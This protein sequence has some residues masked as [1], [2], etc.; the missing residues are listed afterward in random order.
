MTHADRA[1]TQL[2]RGLQA[3]ALTGLLAF[4]VGYTAPTTDAAT[5]SLAFLA[6]FMASLNHYGFGDIDE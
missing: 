5:F 4:I 3:A 6:V 2:K 1:I